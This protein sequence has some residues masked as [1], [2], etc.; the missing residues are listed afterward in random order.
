MSKV[1]FADFIRYASY[2][3]KQKLY[4]KAIDDAVKR[5]RKMIKQAEKLRVR[6]G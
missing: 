1:S 3:Q 6:N 2:E 5:Q 4:Q